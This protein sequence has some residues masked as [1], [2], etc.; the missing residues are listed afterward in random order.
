MHKVYENDD[1]MIF[2]KKRYCHCCGNILKNTYVKKIIKKTDSD[3]FIYSTI[4][5]GYRIYD[6]IL[7]TKKA[8]YCSSCHKI[9]SCFEQSK[10]MSAQKYYKRRIV[11]KKEINYVHDMQ[12]KK[13][14]IRILKYRWILFIPGIGGIICM[15]E[16]F[17]SMLREKTKKYD[18]TKLYIIS[19]VLLI[20]SALIIKN[21]FITFDNIDYL[22]KKIITILMS[23]YSFNIPILIYINNNFN[24]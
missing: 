11:S 17:S 2:N 1:V 14:L 24:K 9:F 19:L 23:L 3:H 10:A 8:Y 7:V 12:L 22:Y 13:L 18:Q 21:I 5:S 6:D 4:G 20:I 15:Y 16:I